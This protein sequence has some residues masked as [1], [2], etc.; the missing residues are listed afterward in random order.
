MKGAIAVLRWGGVTGRNERT[1][2]DLGGDALP[3]FLA[4]NRLLDPSRADT[5]KLDGGRR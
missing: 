1:L 5:S 3:E 4:D 2:R